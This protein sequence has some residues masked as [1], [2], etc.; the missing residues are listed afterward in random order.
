MGQLIKLQNYISRYETDIF[1]YPG[2][3]IRLKRRHWKYILDQWKTEKMHGKNMQ[4]NMDGTSDHKRMRGNLRSLFS[5]EKN[6]GTEQL[7]EI[8]LYDEDEDPYAERIFH[9]S[10]LPETVEQLKKMFLDEIFKVQ[11]LW[12]SSTVFEQSDADHK[13]YREEQLKF[14]LQRFPDTFLVLYKPV[15]LLKRASVECNTILI[16]PF[17]ACCIQF[18][19]TAEDAVYTGSDR[20]FWEMRTNE[21]RSGFLSPLISLQ[22]TETIVKNIWE[23]EGMEFPVSKVLLSRNGYID[24]PSAPYGLHVID[25]RNFEEWF[26]RMRNTEAPLKSNQLKAA[27]SLLRHTETISY[28]RI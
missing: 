24:Y 17:E 2:R 22:R 23:A 14:F 8:T 26:N 21:D 18:L 7:K 6:S 3:F 25:R 13:F 28:A 12:A 27:R 11:V 10:A 4:E 20:R 19:E 1:N 9:T 16:T 15:F 5:K